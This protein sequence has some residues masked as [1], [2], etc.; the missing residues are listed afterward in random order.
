MS[1]I[2]S[3]IMNPNRANTTKQLG[4]PQQQRKEHAELEHEDRY[5]ETPKKAKPDSENTST[6]MNTKNKTISYGKR[7]DSTKGYPG[8][9]PVM[10]LNAKFFQ[11]PTIMGKRM[12]KV[13]MNKKK[14]TNTI[15]Q[16]QITQTAINNQKDNGEQIAPHNHKTCHTESNAV[17]GAY[18]KEINRTH[19]EYRINN[20]FDST[21]GYPGEGPET[22]KPRERKQEKLTKLPICSNTKH[23]TNLN[24]N[25]NINA[26]ANTNINT[27]SNK[28]KGQGSLLIF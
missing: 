25:T 22:D 23:K 20:T 3:T 28:Y 17:K 6:K 2:K 14:A 16:L 8:E 21:K 19:R 1:K 7:F 4:K 26:D 18:L 11:C 10:K 27:N 13:L 15:K 5:N 9:G 12:V 24:T